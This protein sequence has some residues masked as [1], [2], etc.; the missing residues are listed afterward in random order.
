[1]KPIGNPCSYFQQHPVYM[2]VPSILLTFDQH[3]QKLDNLQEYLWQLYTTVHRLHVI[4]TNIIKLTLPT[5]QAAAIASSW[6]QLP[7]SIAPSF[8][9]VAL[10]VP[11]APPK[12]YTTSLCNP[13]CTISPNSSH[14]SEPSIALSLAIFISAIHNQLNQMRS[15]AHTTSCHFVAA[16]L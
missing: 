12:P 14:T 7:P 11:S 15:K 10:E 3:L 1:M 4:I 5:P 6:S 2:L 8:V 13:H 9:T 16:L